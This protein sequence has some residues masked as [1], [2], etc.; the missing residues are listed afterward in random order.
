MREDG[1]QAD[2]VLLGRGLADG[3]YLGLLALDLAEEG[4]G[5][6]LQGHAQEQLLFLGQ[7]HGG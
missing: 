6:L 1:E 2:G 3:E 5:D 7:R 4:L